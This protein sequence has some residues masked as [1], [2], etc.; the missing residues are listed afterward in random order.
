MLGGELTILFVY[1]LHAGGKITGYQVN[2]VPL[3]TL[4]ERNKGKTSS[5][6]TLTLLLAQPGLGFVKKN[7]INFRV[8]FI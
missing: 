7:Q 3:G 8:K 4:V 2:G 6:V 5:L 1:E